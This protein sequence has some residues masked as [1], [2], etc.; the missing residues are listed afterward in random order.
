MHIILSIF[1]LLLLIFHLGF[2][3]APVIHLN[4]F[5]ISFKTP[6]TLKYL[7]SFSSCNP[8][9]ITIWGNICLYS[10][11]PFL[12]ISKLKIG[13]SESCHNLKSDWSLSVQSH[14]IHSKTMLTLTSRIIKKLFSM[15]LQISFKTLNFLMFLIVGVVILIISLVLILS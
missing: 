6:Y 3:R 7:V 9:N 5:S 13:C 15:K 11:F 14:G 4:I 10:V 1:I 8:P 12:H 2:L